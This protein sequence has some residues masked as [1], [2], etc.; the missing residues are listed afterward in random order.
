[1]AKDKSLI[2]KIIAEFLGT[3]ILVFSICTSAT[4]NEGN[5]GSGIGVALAH[6]LSL[7]ALV[8]TLGPISGGHFNPAVTLNFLVFKQID[9]ASSL[10]Y[11]VSQCGGATFGA[12]L[13]RL[14][15]SEENLRITTDGGFLAANKITPGYTLMQGFLAE[16]I[17]TFLLVFTIW[18]VAVNKRS[19]TEFAGWAIGGV[20]G[21]GVFMIG[22]ISNNACNPARALGPAIVM[23]KFYPEQWIYVA[24]PILGAIT[25]GALNKVIEIFSGC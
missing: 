24:G 2:K 21:M 1:M 18:G 25:A 23:M 14:L 7:G 10:T 11:I 22:P 6:F 13:A 17:M 12:L 3:A 5:P 9:V 20:L 8:Y 16:F 4:I 19:A 15:L